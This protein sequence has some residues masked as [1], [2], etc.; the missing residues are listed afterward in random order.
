[1]CALLQKFSVQPKI[2]YDE[3]GPYNIRIASGLW[4]IEGESM[5]IDQ[6]ANQI[7]YTFRSSDYNLQIASN[8]YISLDDA[9]AK[10]FVLKSF[11]Y[12]TD[13]GVEVDMNNDTINV[14]IR[15]N[16]F[17]QTQ[18]AVTME[19]CN[20]YFEGEIINFKTL[21]FDSSIFKH[22]KYIVNRDSEQQII[23]QGDF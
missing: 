8:T 4:D 21:K 12:L 22:G 19:F 23:Y 6:R 7:N 18:N 15:G 20:A 14:S 9:Y 3:L 5:S 1:M 17:H 11:R 13:D 10:Q 16:E 2:C